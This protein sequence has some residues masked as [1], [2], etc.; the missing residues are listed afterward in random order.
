MNVL[1]LDLEHHTLFWLDILSDE[2]MAWCEINTPSFRVIT[3]NIR[4]YTHGKIHAIMVSRD[5]SV[6]F[7]LF[8]HD[9]IIYH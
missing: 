7:K 1:D 2:L 9:N 4:S 8:W 6:M 3:T 5:E